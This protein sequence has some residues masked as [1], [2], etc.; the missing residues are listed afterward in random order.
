LKSAKE[1]SLFSGAGCEKYQAAYNLK[2][3]QPNELRL[4]PAGPIDS[5]KCS[6]HL[7]IAGEA[8]DSDDVVAHVADKKH[9]QDDQR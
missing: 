1:V 2:D 7:Y 9:Q 4:Q 8:P 3:K 5:A 6:H